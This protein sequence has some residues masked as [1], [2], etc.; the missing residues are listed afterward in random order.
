MNES[1]IVSLPL[2]GHASTNAEIAAHLRQQADWIEADER[3]EVRNVFLIIEATDGSLVRQ[4]CG[5]PCDVARAIGVLTA[6]A[7]RACVGDE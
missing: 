4:T 7:T 5:A 1:R 6:A 3:G 2:S